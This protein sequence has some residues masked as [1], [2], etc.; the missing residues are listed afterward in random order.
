MGQ[1]F[2][3]FFYHFNLSSPHLSSEGLR[4]LPVVVQQHRNDEF[5]ACKGEDLDR[6]S[7]VRFDSLSS[8][9]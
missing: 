1:E 5:L 7:E 4:F 8:R 3:R 2:G 6:Y 9:L